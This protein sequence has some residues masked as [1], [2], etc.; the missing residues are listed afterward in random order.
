MLGAVFLFWS[1]W[2]ERV[3]HLLR[4]RLFCRHSL[5]VSEPRAAL[6]APSALASGARTTTQVNDLRVHLVPCTGNARHAAACSSSKGSFPAQG[7]CVEPLRPR[8]LRF[9]SATPAGA[10]VCTSCIN[11]TGHR[12]R[13]AG[14]ISSEADQAPAQARASLDCK[15]RG[16]EQ[17][18]CPPSGAESDRK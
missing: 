10:C 2:R 9:S 1:A 15:P 18:S 3:E 13:Q 5:A 4:A 12:P 6:W 17:Q 14:R 8:R 7:M 11:G 16:A